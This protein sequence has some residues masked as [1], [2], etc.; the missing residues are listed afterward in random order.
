MNSSWKIKFAFLKINGRFFQ[1]VDGEKPKSRQNMKNLIKIKYILPVLLIAFLLPLSNGI[2]DPYSVSLKMDSS[3][4]DRPEE[5]KEVICD[6][7]HFQDQDLL[8]A[9][10]MDHL[11]KHLIFIP[12]SELETIISS[13]LDC[14][15]RYDMNPELIFSVIHT[16]STFNSSAISNKGAIGL[17]QLMPSTAESIAQELNIEWS[18]EDMLYDPAINIE[19]GTYYLHF[20]IN[21]F[22]DMDAALSAYNIGPTRISKAIKKGFNPKSRFA[23]IVKKRSLELFLLKNTQAI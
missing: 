11:H 4:K 8:S 21:N 17:M 22:N 9:M 14:S 15:N 13:V 1:F 20:L 12:E 5:V 7:R 18:G 3:D 6:Y 10:M 19:L 16:E 23:A 2:G